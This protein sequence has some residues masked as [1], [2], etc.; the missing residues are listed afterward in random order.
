VL[1]PLLR[2]D[3]FDGQRGRLLALAFGVA[4]GDVEGFQRVG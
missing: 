2:Q 1:I 3:V 4:E